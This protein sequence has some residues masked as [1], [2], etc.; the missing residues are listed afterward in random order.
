M[1]VLKGYACSLDWPRPN[2]RPC[3]DIDIWL[4]G[5]QKGADKLVESLEFRVDRSHHHHTVFDWGGF[6]VENHYDFVNVHARRSSRELEKV[7]KELG[8]DDSHFVELGGEKV[9]LPSPDLH[10]LFLLKHSMTDFAAFFVT[11]RQVLD[12]AFFVKAHTR[13]IDWK[14][15]TK[16]LED[17]HMLDFFNTI[18]AI[19]VENLGF[20]V[21]IFP[22]IQ[23]SPILK[24][25][26]LSDIL[27]PEFKREVP[28]KLIPRFLYMFRRWKGN[29]WKH[30]ICYK[31]SLW[32]AFCSGIWN[33]LLKPAHI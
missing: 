30:R 5:Q 2:H 20:D 18:N 29:A 16:E 32:S 12:W 25:R 28:K 3:G 27:T 8:Q 14:W 1:M 26:V 10:A 7:F 19:C 33:H 13:E 15:L 6:A 9:Y 22:Y 31:E 4:F 17:F 23:F 11:L 21:N 24:D